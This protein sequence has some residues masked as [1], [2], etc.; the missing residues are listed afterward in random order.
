ML[1]QPA[2]RSPITHILLSPQEAYVIE[3]K[4]SNLGLELGALNISSAIPF[5]RLENSQR[6]SQNDGMYLGL[7]L[8]MAMTLM[9]ALSIQQLE[10]ESVR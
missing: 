2:L 3:R 7:E 5:G 10:K 1:P 9:L 6:H 4:S 8:F